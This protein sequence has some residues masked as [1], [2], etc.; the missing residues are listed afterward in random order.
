MAAHDLCYAEDGELAR[1]NQLSI[2]GKTGDFTWK[3]PKHLKSYFDAH[4]I[5]A[6]LIDRENRIIVNGKI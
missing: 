1:L 4:G 6:R 2:D 5:K 3:N